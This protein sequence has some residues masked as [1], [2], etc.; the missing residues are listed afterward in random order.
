MFHLRSKYNPKSCGYSVSVSMVCICLTRLQA[1]T[2]W[3]EMG[4]DTMPM[5]YVLVS[6]RLSFTA[7]LQTSLHGF[8]ASER[9]SATWVTALIGPCFSGMPGK[10]MQDL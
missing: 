8:H 2:V 1:A 9:L 5:A 6:M 4:L 3:T 7:R 10:S